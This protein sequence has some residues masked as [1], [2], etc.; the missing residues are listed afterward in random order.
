M[1]RVRRRDRLCPGPLPSTGD[2]LN[3]A[4]KRSGFVTVQTPNGNA[5]TRNG[6]LHIETDGTLTA[7]RLSVLARPARPSTSARAATAIIGND[8]SLD[9][10]GLPS[11]QIAMADP[12]GAE[13]IPA[14]SSLYRTADGAFFRRDQQPDHQGLSDAPSE[15]GT[16]VRCWR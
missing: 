13:M 7:V 16:I 15:M 11:G 3:V 2:P 10:N 14:G 5:Y 4:I 6:T 12:T 9:I 1:R 8:G